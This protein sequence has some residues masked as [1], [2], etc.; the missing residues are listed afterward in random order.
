MEQTFESRLCY[1][2]SRPCPGSVFRWIIATVKVFNWI[3]GETRH[4]AIS[5]LKHPWTDPAAG[6]REQFD[7]KE[8][9]NWLRLIFLGEVSSPPPIVRETLRHLRCTDWAFNVPVHCLFLPPP[10]FCL[11]IEK[12]C[13]LAPFRHRASIVI[14]GRSPQFDAPVRHMTK[15]TFFW[16]KKVLFFVK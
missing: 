8:S 1:T 12:H 16:Q 4:F 15:S 14:S 10:R 5:P 13:D 6:I 7:M 11:P 3:K 9:S 2:C